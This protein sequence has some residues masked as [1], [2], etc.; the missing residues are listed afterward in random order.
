MS[1]AAP[2]LDQFVKDW[3]RIHKQSAKVMQ[4]APDDKYDWKPVESGMTLGELLNHLVQSEWGLV[5]AAF[6]GKW[7][8]GGMPAVATNTADLIATYTKSH[9][10]C[11]A[12]IASLTSEQLGETIAPFGPDKAMTRGA[13]IHLMLEHEIHHRGQVYTYL[14][15]AGAD[16]PPLFG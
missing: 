13:L 16:V 14:R 2:H 1:A 12:R 6:T 3:N 5:D 7:P 11:V 10:E 9:E 15:I 4:A 8:E